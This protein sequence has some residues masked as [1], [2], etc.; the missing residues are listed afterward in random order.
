LVGRTN[1]LASSLG[2]RFSGLEFRE[3]RIDNFQSDEFDHLN[4]G[5]KIV[6]ALHACDTATDDA[7]YF[8]IRAKADVILT[9]PCC[10]KEVRRQIDSFASTLSRGS[11]EAGAVVYLC[12]QLYLSM[13]FNDN[14]RL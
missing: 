6:I 1:E 14:D 8:G 10:H 11:M 12:I 5:L 4:S 7:I 9:A 3:G 13:S 2:E